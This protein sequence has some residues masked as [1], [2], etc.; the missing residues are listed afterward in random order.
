MAVL[1]SSMRIATFLAW[2]LCAATA[3]ASVPGQYLVFEVDRHD[4]ITL[5]AVEDVSFATAPSWSNDAGADA[6]EIELLDSAG[7]TIHRTTR[8]VERAFR[9]EPGQVERE[10]TSFVVRVPR[11]GDSVRVNGAQFSVRGVPSK[12]ATESIRPKVRGESTTSPNRLDLLIVGDGYTAAQESR[13]HS[14][15]ARMSDEFFSIEPYRTYRSYINVSS[16]FVPSAE[17]GADHPPCSDPS[18]DPKAGTFVD[19]AFDATFCT[20]QILRLL[21]VSTWK[22]E[23][24]ASVVPDWD[25]IMVL[26]NDPL[27]GG[28]GGSISVVS[29]NEHATRVL[30]HEFGHTFSWLGDEY[31]APL[32]G[33]P[34]L[35]RD[36]PGAPPYL[37]C[38]PNVTDQTERASIKWSPWI[39]PSTPLPTPPGF[40]GIGLFLGANYSY[41][42]QY[43]PKNECLMNLGN[44]FCEICA[45]EFIL[46]MYSGWGGVPANGVSPIESVTPAPGGIRVTP[47]VPIEFHASLLHTIEGAPD[48]QWLVDGA[49][50]SEGTPSFTYMPT[51]ATTK[52]E[53]RVTDPT[54]RVHPLMSNGVLTKTRAWTLHTSGLPRRRAVGH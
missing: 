39:D 20:G 22:V 44:F 26:V 7:R 11:G 42:G 4:K 37:R 2:F 10:R 23:L 41:V 25:L 8:R 53:L 45:Q 16:L 48:V 15:V 14:D 34:Q 13:F 32:P 5:V 43:R 29:R 40:G 28:A 21:T 18:F 38:P 19:T 1:F 46:R 49:V 35:C 47:G 12:I 30:Q 6:F 51:D 50:V 33:V 31:S 52:I 3:S 24:A 17:E 27:Y 54:K 9:A 36:D